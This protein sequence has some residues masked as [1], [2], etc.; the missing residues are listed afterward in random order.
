MAIG[1]RVPCGVLSFLQSWEPKTSFEGA[2]HFV[3]T[4]WKRVPG[5]DEGDLRTA[6]VNT[7]LYPIRVG[8]P[9]SK[10]RIFISVIFV[11]SDLY[12]KNVK[13]LNPRRQLKPR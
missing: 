6:D 4:F 7:V 12:Y 1:T 3:T 11:R 13:Y 10:H 2:E 9:G 5:V 8:P